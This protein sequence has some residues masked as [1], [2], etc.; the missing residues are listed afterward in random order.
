MLAATELL[1]PA[2]LAPCPHLGLR[3]LFYCVD[4]FPEMK[5]NTNIFPPQEKLKQVQLEKWKTTQ[6]RSLSL[7]PPH[8]F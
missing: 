4:W 5:F 2:Q 6:E 8:Y 1:N 3:Q 7:N